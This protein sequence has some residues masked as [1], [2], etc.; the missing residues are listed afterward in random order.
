MNMK[1]ESEPLAPALPQTLAH[2]Q[3]ARGRAEA[4]A[5]R[6]H[7]ALNRLGGPVPDSCADP[8][9]ASN[10]TNVAEELRALAHDMEALE[11]VLQRAASRLEDLV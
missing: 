2:I 10:R 7:D 1:P 3:G 6:I 11:R 8:A 4:A 9:A 5:W